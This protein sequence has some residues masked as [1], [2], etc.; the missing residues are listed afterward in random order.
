MG[1]INEGK[2]EFLTWLEY[3]L[4]NLTIL[5]KIQVYL[6]PMLLTN[7]EHWQHTMATSFD[8]CPLSKSDTVIVPGGIHN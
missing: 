4:L 7:S 8:S 5:A 2:S 1:Q 3:I 6:T